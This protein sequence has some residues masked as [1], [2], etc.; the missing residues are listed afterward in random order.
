MVDSENLFFTKYFCEA[1]INGDGTIFSHW[2]EAARAW[3]LIDVIREA[4]DKETSE[5]PTYAARTMGTKAAFDL[6][7]KNGHEWAWQP[8][9]WYQERGYYNK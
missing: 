7:E 5:L 4:W 9:L 2:E 6:L 1:V 8:D 3:E